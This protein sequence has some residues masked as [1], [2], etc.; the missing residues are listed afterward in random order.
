MKHFT[1]MAAMI[2]CFALLLPVLAACSEQDREGSLSA[3]NLTLDGAAVRWSVV[4]G[5]ESYNIYIDGTLKTTVTAYRYSLVTLQAGTYVVTVSAVAGDKES[6]MSN[7]VTYTKQLPS[8]SGVSGV[9]ME[10]IADAL[11]DYSGFM[12]KIEYT[13]LTRQMK[14]P[15]LWADFVEQFRSNTDEP[16]ADMIEDTNGGGWRGEFWGKLMM[17]ATMFYEQTQDEELY[18]ILEATTRDLLTTQDEE[19]RIGTYGKLSQGGVEFDHWDVWCRKL[20]MQGMQYF[21]DICKDEDL[22]EQLVESMLA[23]LDYI[24]RYV[25]DG[26]GKMSILDTGRSMGGMASASILEAIV[27]LYQMTGEQRVLDFA[28]HIVE[29]G[30]SKNAN[31]VEA[32]IRNEGDP[33]QW[34]APK[35]YEFCSFF[36]GVLD[37]YMLT[38]EEKYKTA[39]VNAAYKVLESEVAVTGG[40]GYQSEEFNHAVAEQAN[41][42]N[43]HGNLEGC[44]ATAI[45]QLFS[46]AYWVTG[47]PVF[48]DALERTMYNAIYGAMDKEGN[49]DHVFTS[50][51]NLMFSTKPTSAGGGLYLPTVDRSYGCCIAFG[52]YGM[53]LMHRLHYTADENALYANYYLAGDVTMNTPAG[54]TVTLTT[55][56]TYPTSGTVKITVHTEESQNFVLKLRIPA[57]SNTT[58]VAVNGIGMS[59]IRHGEYLTLSRQW[60]NGDTIIL[61][62]DMHATLYQGSA[63]CSNANGKNNVAVMY[64][65]LVLARD[66]RL[67]QDIFQTVQ[68]AVDENGYLDITP[69]NRADFGTL[70]EFDVKL[71]NG[72]TIAMIDYAS[73]GGTYNEESLFTVFMPTTDYWD[74]TGSLNRS[75]YLVSSHGNTIAGVR[76][77]MLASGG[78][79][80]DYVDLSGFEMKLIDRGNGYYTIGKAGSD[81]VLTAV[82]RNGDWRFAEQAYTGADTQLFKLDRSSLFTYRIISKLNGQL[83][84]LDTASNLLHLYTDVSSSMQKWQLM[85][86]H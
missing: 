36:K 15:Q 79:L 8:E 82:Q 62:L 37:Y 7:S 77:G 64:G 33:Y 19:G 1:K 50:Y 26:E 71:A 40:A 80:Q 63:E 10:L 20:V 27:R 41:P 73:A 76:D 12:S 83:L 3:P 23:Q 25:G 72:S 51:F 47:D 39:G 78:F 75:V 31:L 49:Y 30:G 45:T 59:N 67:G 84:S 35:G 11:Y 22:K 16:S 58:A 32:A 46:N 53:G 66:R 60:E 14:D 43:T 17:G 55:E 69:A 13:V 38:G 44:V 34:G 42:E 74:T 57:W 86:A 56:T 54:K 2:L 81:L 52:A 6:A 29:S 4:D 21:Y 48:I 5:A 28:K 65:P 70:A 85:P 68:F 24:M 61:T 18:A 9:A